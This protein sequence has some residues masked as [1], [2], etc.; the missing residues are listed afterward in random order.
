M[1]SFKETYKWPLY[2]QLLNKLWSRT[3]NYTEFVLGF[4]YEVHLINKVEHYLK[5]W[6]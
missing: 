1:S 4:M 6:Q 2:D 5:T 3:Y